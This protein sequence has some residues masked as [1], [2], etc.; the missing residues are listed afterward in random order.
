MAFNFS[1]QNSRVIEPLV[2][3]C[4]CWAEAT[5]YDGDISDYVEN[6]I[7]QNAY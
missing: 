4:I 1:K 3:A 6:K 7:D 2:F 5:K